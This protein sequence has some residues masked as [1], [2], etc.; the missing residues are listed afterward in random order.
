M[1]S[2][3]LISCDVPDRGCKMAHSC[4]VLFDKEGLNVSMSFYGPGQQMKLHTHETTQV[5][6][7]LAGHMLESS[8]F[9]A[10]DIHMPSC[11][12][13]PAG[14]E[15]ANDYGRHGALILA[16]NI[17]HADPAP[18]TGFDFDDWRWSPRLAGTYQSGLTKSLVDLMSKCG[19]EAESAVWDLLALSTS[20]EE[21][22]SPTAPVWLSRVR[23]QLNE[24]DQALDLA[25]MA[26]QA[27]VHRVYLSRAFTHCFGTPPS[28]YRARCRVARGVAAMMQGESLVDAALDAGFADQSHFSRLAKQ[29]IGLP[30][31]RLHGLLTAA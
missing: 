25:L 27:G 20:S 23:D 24:C 8:R 26:K 16:I 14:L 22:A 30:P 21:F 3:Y 2:E 1:L 29:Q 5:S 12:V 18:E 28:V 6:W 10:R 13:K 11:G 4:K 31:K 7:L 9:R 15:H 17:D 19:D